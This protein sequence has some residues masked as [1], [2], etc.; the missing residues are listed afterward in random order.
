MFVTF[1]TLAF[2]VCA[3][4]FGQCANGFWLFLSHGLLFGPLVV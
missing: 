2:D 1:G 4:V 3:L